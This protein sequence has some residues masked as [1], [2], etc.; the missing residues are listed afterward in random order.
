[1]TKA[2]YI[3][4]REECLKLFDTY[5]ML[6]NIRAHSIQVTR[7]ALLIADNLKN[8]AM[9][10]RTLV[11]AAAL[12]HDI[13]KT[14]S[15]QT[16]EKFHD[17]TGQ[18]LLEE[19]GMKKIGDIVGA[20]VQLRDCDCSGELTEKEIVFYSDKRVRHDE[21][22]S[23]EERMDDLVKRYGVNDFALE[24]IESGKKFAFDLEA[25]I[26]RHLSKQLDDVIPLT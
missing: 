18:K 9:I 16:G 11:E 13:T 15:I 19:L 26:S 4:S 3:P 2:D 24:S 10:N 21:I 23:L 12:L 8:P 20:H 14:R 7:V 25:K 22:V 17:K 6:D 1:M 5:Q